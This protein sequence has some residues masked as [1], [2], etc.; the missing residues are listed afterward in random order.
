MQVML[1]KGDPVALQKLG[2]AINIALAKAS[3]RPLQPL[4]SNVNQVPFLQLPH[5]RHIPHTLHSI[6]AWYV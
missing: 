2:Q 4:S 1:S 5:H 3:N 6:R